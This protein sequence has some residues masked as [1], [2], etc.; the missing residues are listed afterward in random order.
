MTAAVSSSTTAP[1]E[2]TAKVG[3]SEV[4]WLFVEKYYSLMNQAPQR[5][6]CFYNKKSAFLHG[7]EGEAT[8]T[9]C[10][11]QQEIHSRIVDLDFNDC[12][13]LVSQVDVQSSLNGG[14]VVQVLGEMSN[15]GGPTHKF[16]QTF[17]LAEQPNGYYVLNDI[18][19]FLKEDIDNEYED[20][21][22]PVGD[23]DIPDS[24][25]TEDN[26]ASFKEPAPVEP[27]QQRPASPR[28]P[29][30]KARSPSPVKEEVTV[31]PETPVTNSE[32]RAKEL[33]VP[34]ESYGLGGWDA[35]PNAETSNDAKS[36]W[37]SVS[38]GKTSNAPEHP[39]PK[40]TTTPAS[41][42]ATFVKSSAAPAA[43]P[44]AAATPN[45]PRSWASLAA[46]NAAGWP[47]DAS[48][49]KAN[50][51][52]TQT[53]APATQRPIS[54]QRPSAQPVEKPAF[55]E[56]A[57]SRET[58]SAAEAKDGGFRE[59]QNRQHKRLSQGAPQQQHHH[60]Q[61]Q[62][63]QQQFVD[64]DKEKYQIY[65]RGV[66]DAIDKKALVET[67]SKVGTVRNVDLLLPKNMAFVEFTTIEAAQK[68]IGNS[69][70]V[71][72]VKVHAEERRKPRPYN[73]RPAG[74]YGQRRDYHDG[75]NRG[76][77]EFH[78]RGGQGGR[79]RGGYNGA[80]KPAPAGNKPLIN[81][82]ASNH[83][84]NEWYHKYHKLWK[85]IAAQTGRSE[86][87]SQD[88]PGSLDIPTKA[89]TSRPLPA[90]MNA[91]CTTPPRGRIMT[92]ASPLLC[93]GPSY[94]QPVSQSHHRWLSSLQKA[95]GLGLTR[96]SNVL[97]IHG[98]R[99]RADPNESRKR[100]LYISRCF[101]GTGGCAMFPTSDS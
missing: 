98:Q 26:S 69:F 30:E 93:V 92:S 38:K 67:F 15:N 57:S 23:I 84:S 68:A 35:T 72:G 58:G 19:R 73:N 85:V 54:P 61:Q 101:P 97:Q 13:V 78:N 7:H 45:K 43:A 40:K 24:F 12:K 52:A 5:L 22:D 100:R 49:A 70:V 56:A 80:P 34:T 29:I 6:H 51:N 63:Q 42:P 1:T 88:L 86:I 89:C 59:V 8:A 64:D 77:G 76:R 17:F 55:T 82:G 47:A 20:A 79:A 99:S 90:E 4:G 39:E 44:A 3:A 83:E 41:A 14:I 66:T 81:Y 16:A 18:F 36:A 46:T 75:A 48:P 9:V 95:K 11:G 27:E 94:N 74:Q 33:P 60:H 53:P 28:K 91:S 37:A 65:I 32:P 25:G 96:M 10:Q 62:D 50:N 71:A 31:A 2:K 21:E 87:V